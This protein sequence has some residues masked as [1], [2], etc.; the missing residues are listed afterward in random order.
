MRSEYNYTPNQTVTPNA[1]A[2]PVTYN[3][4]TKEW[5]AY[6]MELNNDF[7]EIPLPDGLRVNATTVAHRGY[8]T[9][10]TG[11]T[12]YIGQHIYANP[13]IIGAITTEQTSMI[14]LGFVISATTILVSIR[15]EMPRDTRAGFD[16]IITDDP[17]IHSTYG[18]FS[19]AT[20]LSAKRMA[21]DTDNNFICIT[22][23]LKVIQINLSMDTIIRTYIETSAP[24][25]VAIDP[26][27]VS[28]T[29]R[30]FI[31]LSNDTIKVYNAST[32]AY[33]ETFGSSGSGNGEFSGISDMEYTNRDPAYLSHGDGISKLM[34][35]STGISPDLVTVEIKEIDYLAQT[36]GM[37]ISLTSK[38]NNHI[39]DAGDHTTGVDAIN[40]I[41]SPDP[42]DLDMLITRV[43]EMLNDYTAHNDDALLATPLYHAAQ[44]TG[45]TLVSTAAPTNLI[46]CMVRL[47]NI[48]A[49]FNGHDADTTA[50]GI[51]S[52][53]QMAGADAGTV[54]ATVSVVSND[55]IVTLAATLG[56]KTSIADD[57]KT[58]LD[59]S[60][61]ASLINTTS[62]GTG[63]VFP[64]VKTNLI[65]QCL[66]V[67]ETTNQRIQ[68][69]DT[70][71]I[72][73][74]KID[75][76][77]QIHGIHII[78]SGI[79]LLSTDTNG[80]FSTTN[81]G[82]I[83]TQLINYGAA[84][85][86]VTGPCGL[87]TDT[88]GD[89]FVADNTLNAFKLFTSAG[90]Y[91]RQINAR[92]KIATDAPVDV[93]MDG[94][95]IYLLCEENCSKGTWNFS[96]VI[97][98]GTLL[99]YDTSINEWIQAVGNNFGAI[100][101]ANNKLLY[102]GHSPEDISDNIINVNLT[103]YQY[104]FRNIT[105]PEKIEASVTPMASR[106]IG[107]YVKGHGFYFRGDT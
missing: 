92:L 91:I 44:T 97:D 61:A 7:N 59:G 68:T 32:G 71:L 16:P 87:V 50:H 24:V 39:S 35:E 82:Q 17:F 60:S 65:G 70:S 57:I 106:K 85:G 100:K 107:Y 56:V 86:E 4:T 63:L 78:E 15:K 5:G 101:I 26:G 25:A 36:I 18:T 30:L 104:V 28:G 2:G 96:N 95:T 31:A 11:L 102:I 58:L 77:Y 89:V 45:H 33:I 13:Y 48:K 72:Y 55:I 79:I 6:I 99:E 75:T 12:S 8:V 88:S 1:V 10:F 49:T 37:A 47:N 98:D 43:I 54:P 83:L 22:D 105:N 9:G 34:F 29:N 46:E 94:T 80:I 81:N 52:Q 73:L 74:R 41:T 20:S 38:Y 76:A 69:F 14:H 62:G 51:G 103:L 21:I 19:G 40:A 27:T 84:E 64:L 42:T 23:G 3:P 66:F 53:Y 67:S 93:V 90:V